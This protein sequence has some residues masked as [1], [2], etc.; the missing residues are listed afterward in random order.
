MIRRYMSMAFIF[1]CFVAFWRANDGNVEV[2]TA[3]V[4]SALNV[5]ADIVLAVWDGV[6]SKG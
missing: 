4:M 3:S 2:M 1:V 5:G 6:F